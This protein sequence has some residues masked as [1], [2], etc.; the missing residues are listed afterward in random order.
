VQAALD[1]RLDPATRSRLTV[2]VVANGD[3]S[4]LVSLDKGIHIGT[5]LFDTDQATI[6]PAYKPLVAAIAKALNAQ[7][8]GVLSLVGR[9]DHRGADAYNTQLGL[10]RAKAVYDAIAADLKPEVREK[11]RVEVSDNPNA[12]LGVDKR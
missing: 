3:P 2:N 11:V 6:R 8:G 12:P 7:G 1:K 10:K 9:A 4:P 5:L